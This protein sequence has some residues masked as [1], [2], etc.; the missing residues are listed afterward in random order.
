M[1]VTPKRLMMMEVPLCPLWV[2][3]EDQP[4]MTKRQRPADALNLPG[5]SAALRPSGVGFLPVNESRWAVTAVLSPYSADL[6]VMVIETSPQ[7]YRPGPERVPDVEGDG[8]VKLWTAIVENMRSRS[9]DANVNLGYNWSPRAWGEP[10]ERTGFASIPTKWHAQIWTW[11]TK[12][13][14]PHARWAD[15]S[16]INAMERRLILE[17]DYGVPLGRL[18]SERILAHWPDKASTFRRIFQAGTPV[19]DCRGA[20]FQSKQPLAE[21]LRTPGLFVEVL[22][23]LAQLLNTLFKDLTQIMTDMPC[24]AIDTLL[25]SLETDRTPDLPA[26]LEILRR[27]PTMRPAAQIRTALQ[28]HGYP[29]ELMSVLCEPIRLR[30]HEEGDSLTW[31]RKGFGYALAFCDSPANGTVLRIMPGLFLGVGGVVEALGVALRRP[32]DRALPD[33]I[34]Q[35]KGRD[36]CAL[37]RQLSHTVKGYQLLIG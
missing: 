14:E 13:C 3:G 29:E 30:C 33:Q 31:W 11:P 7:L 5:L 2:P 22:K 15:A 24:D 28:Q 27:R 34:I 20:I 8:V 18:I 9:P 21:I 26:M 12:P 23:P 25:A 1:A 17:N 35:T 4:R 37:S 36:V 10:E 32:E 16:A 19:A 6:H